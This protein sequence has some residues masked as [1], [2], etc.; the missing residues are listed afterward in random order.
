MDTF[1]E[2]S[3]VHLWASI[4][5]NDLNLLGEELQKSFLDKQTIFCSQ[6][7]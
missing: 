4:A 1:L 7:C 6:M 5:N 3:I 2:A